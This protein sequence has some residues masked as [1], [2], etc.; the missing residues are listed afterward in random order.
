MLLKKI[1]NWFVEGKIYY[2]RAM[3]YLGILN[4][5][6]IALIFLNTTLWEYHAFQDIFPDRKIFLGIGTVVII[7]FI[8]VLGYL[9]TKLKLW[10][11]EA[12]RNFTPDRTPVMI[13]EAFQCAKMLNELKAKKIDTK[14]LEE[15]LDVLF[16]ACA[17][18]KEFD[19]FKK[20]AK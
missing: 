17:L 9:D 15:K 20:S 4:F 18:E 2:T 12:S 16:K 11:V 7:V 14:E 8:W 6:M 5:L 13:P 19:F 3:T 1:R 10:H